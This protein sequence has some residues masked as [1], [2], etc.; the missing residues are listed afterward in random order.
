MRQTSIPTV[1]AAFLLCCLKTYADVKVWE[2][3]RTVPADLSKR[4]GWKSA[5]AG[6]KGGGIVMENHWLLA[7]VQPGEKGLVLCTKRE[8]NHPTRLIL[9]LKGEDGQRFATDQVEVRSI[10]TDEAVVR[11]RAGKAEV[12]FVIGAGQPFIT[13]RPVRD[14]AYLEIQANARYALLPDFFGYDVVY[15]PKRFASPALSVPA[16]NFL[17]SLLEGNQAIVMCVWPGHLSEAASHK[18]RKPEQAASEDRDPRV[19][20]QMKGEGD[21]RCVASA[22][23]EFL[24]K[25]VHVAVLEH[26]RIWHDEP[27]ANLPVQEPVKIGWKRPFDAKWRADMIVAEGKKSRDLLSRSQSYNLLYPPKEVVRTEEWTELS[28]KDGCPWVHE[29]RLW[30]YRYPAWFNGDDT[31]F[32]VFMDDP[33]RKQKH[34]ESERVKAE[35]ARREGRPYT[36]TPGQFENIYERALIYPLDRHEK[37]PL[38]IF[39]PADIMSQTLGRGP[40]EYIVDLDGIAPREGSGKEGHK[41]LAPSTCLLNKQHIAPIL[42]RYNNSREKM[43]GRPMP[44][45]D[46]VHL[47]RAAKDLAIFLH[48]V[49]ERIAEYKAFND[50]L[51]T[52]CEEAKKN[53]AAAASVQNVE[54]LALGMRQK[55]FGGA[56]ASRLE[57]FRKQL[58]QWDDKIADIVRQI[59]ADNFDPAA[60]VR[61]LRQTTILGEAQDIT[62]A[63]CRRYVKA[64]QQEVALSE[65]GDPTAARFGSE[66]RRMCQ[67]ILRR[68]HPRELLQSDRGK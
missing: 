66:V 51:V 49:H 52:I 36:P 58:E 37:T 38:N 9:A 20:L 11:V 5:S 31:F 27:V 29:E 50:R 40:C 7:A 41:L 6:T 16:E 56:A 3:E 2:T 64:I 22:S 8:E 63:D 1:A 43:E 19:E 44:P 21:T 39:T 14:A 65:T 26:E 34:D 32:A 28:W 57:T 67:S 62:V 18:E 60:T 25:P 13:A 30:G 55:L 47:T 53:P 48:A 61:E 59:E 33:R 15:D 42:L 12:D 24:G 23:I 54:E 17:V 68:G 46:K 45:G 4:E 35:Q 10:E